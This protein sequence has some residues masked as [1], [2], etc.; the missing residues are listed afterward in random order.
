MFLGF[1]GFVFFRGFVWSGF[2][3]EVGFCSFVVVDGRE[4]I[5]SSGK[6]CG[7]FGFGRRR[8]FGSRLVGVF[9]EDIIVLEGS[10]GFAGS[11]VL[12]GGAWIWLFLRYVLNKIF[13]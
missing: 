7:S 6:F 4:G 1:G 9:G 13:F 11:F 10:R 12:A 2:G 5:R 3:V 8:R